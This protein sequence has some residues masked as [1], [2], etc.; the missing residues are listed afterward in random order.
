M[1]IKPEITCFWRIKHVYKR[2]KK[3]LENLF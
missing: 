3:N 2:Q 1:F